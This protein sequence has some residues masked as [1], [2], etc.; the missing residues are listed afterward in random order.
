MVVVADAVVLRVPLSRFV[1]FVFVLRGMSMTVMPLF[2][3]IPLLF[4]FSLPV[5][6]PVAIPSIVIF[7][8]LI[9]PVAAMAAP[10]P[11]VL[12]VSGLAFELLQSHLCLGCQH[13]PSCTLVRG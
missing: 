7:V 3:A 1:I 4:L 11:P 12:V 9:V 10:P 13:L 5:L 2:G 6:L 8:V